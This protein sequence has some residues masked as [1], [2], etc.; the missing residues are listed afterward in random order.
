MEAWARPD[1]PRPPVRL[2]GLSFPTCAGERAPSSAQ[3][4]LRPIDLLRASRPPFP[5]Q[6]WV[7]GGRAGG[8]LGISLSLAS[9]C[10]HRAPGGGGTLAGF[11]SIRCS[12]EERGSSCLL[13]ASAGGW[14]GSLVLGL[15][16]PHR[17]APPAASSFLPPWLSFRGLPCPQPRGKHPNCSWVWS[18]CIHPLVGSATSPGAEIEPLPPT[19]GPNDHHLYALSP[20]ASRQLR[21]EGFQ[22]RTVSAPWAMPAQLWPLNFRCV[23]SPG[24]LWLLGALTSNSLFIC[25][26]LAAWPLQ[27]WTGVPNTMPSFHSP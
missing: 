9:R 8:P 14:G 5:D 2:G 11:R 17:E 18:L 6:W 20:L 10:L 7:S 15:S 21:R 13:D 16:S 24:D 4:P 3:C 26:S 23:S 12:T 22:P 1:S 25:L 19:A 27:T